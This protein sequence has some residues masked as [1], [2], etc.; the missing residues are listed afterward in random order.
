[1]QGKHDPFSCVTN[2]DD[3]DDGAKLVWQTSISSCT[4]WAK[5]SGYETACSDASSF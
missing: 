3:D 4:S 5:L 2:D 1:M